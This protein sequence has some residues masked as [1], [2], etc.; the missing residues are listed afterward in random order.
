MRIK[1]S[2]QPVSLK[3]IFH[4][5]E[6]E[7]IAGLKERMEQELFMQLDHLEL[8]EFLLPPSGLAKNVLREDDLVTAGIH[9]L[10]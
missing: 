6:N 9:V 2:V 8:D 5:N 3:L 7:D 10:F 1:L 4:V